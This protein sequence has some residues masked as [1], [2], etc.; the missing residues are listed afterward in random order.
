MFDRKIEEIELKH[1]V[2]EKKYKEQEHQLEMF[3]RESHRIDKEVQHTDF[4]LNKVQP[5][6]L[7][8]NQV[9]MLRS[10]IDDED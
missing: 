9:T 3:G 5:I 8:T 6:S 1:A 10:I 4:F 2:L 7:F